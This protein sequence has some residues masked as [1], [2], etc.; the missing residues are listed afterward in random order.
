VNIKERKDDE[1]NKTQHILDLALFTLKH[2]TRESDLT[3][4]VSQ[5]ETWDSERK[6]DDGEARMR[7]KEDEEF[8]VVMHV[9]NN[10]Y[11]LVYR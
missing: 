6:A 4:L 7:I 8:K 3:K 11:P 1:F 5:L 9:M 10:G 2:S